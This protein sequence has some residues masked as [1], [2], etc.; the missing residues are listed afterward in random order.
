MVYQVADMAIR[1]AR[2][3]DATDFKITDSQNLTVLHDQRVPRDLIRLQG[4]G[5]NIQ[6][7]TFCL[8]ISYPLHVSPDMVRMMM[9]A[10]D[11]PQLCAILFF[12]L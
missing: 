5:N 6:I 8:L 10:K 3:F 11:V 7:L 1:M 12:Y 9:C 4:A 2:C